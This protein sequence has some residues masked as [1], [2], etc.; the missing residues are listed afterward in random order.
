[1]FVFAARRA[2]RWTGGQ[3]DRSRVDR[4]KGNTLKLLAISEAAGS[5][6]HL[7]CCAMKMDSLFLVLTERVMCAF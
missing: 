5:S 1:M 4:R 7:G 6:Q 3:A 2:N